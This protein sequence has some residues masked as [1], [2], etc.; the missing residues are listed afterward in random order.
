MVQN[1]DINPTLGVDDHQLSSNLPLLL[2]GGERN[3]ITGKAPQTPRQVA[4]VW[5]AV[6]PMTSRSMAAGRF[7]GEKNHGESSKTPSRLGC[8]LAVHCELGCF[9]CCC[10]PTLK[11]GVAA[12]WTP[13]PCRSQGR[14]LT[15]R[16]RKA[17][18][19]TKRTGQQSWNGT[20]VKDH[21]ELHRI[22]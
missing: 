12:S 3:E 5:Y 13:W 4:E 9:F 22:A 20:K 17:W 1:H 8:S 19:K 16:I 7:F 14:S 2:L 10:I 21:T 11:S 15:E 18:I 6:K